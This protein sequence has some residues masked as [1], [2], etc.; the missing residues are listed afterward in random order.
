MLFTV[1]LVDYVEATGDQETGKEL[2]HI[3]AKQ[4]EFFTK[5]FTEALEYKVE[6]KRADEGGVGWHFID[7]ESWA[8]GIGYAS[9]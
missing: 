8:N 5:N 7:C 1:T 4:F 6:N 3:A 9:S 2:F